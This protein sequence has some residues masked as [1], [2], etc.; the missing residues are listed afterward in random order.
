[1]AVPQPKEMPQNSQAWFIDKL[2]SSMKKFGAE[3]WNGKDLIIFGLEAYYQLM[4][5]PTKNDR[6]M[7]DDVLCLLSDRL[8]LAVNANLDPTGFRKGSGHSSSKGMGTIHY[9]VHK[10]AY[11]IGWHKQVY[12]AVR[13]VGE[14]TVRREASSSQKADIVIDGISYYF[15]KGSH[16]AMNM[17]PARLTSTSSLGCQTLPVGH[18]WDLFI[19]AIVSESKRLN[20]KRFTYVKARVRG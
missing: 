2:Q 12:P 20:Q 5:D 18:Q 1:M 16:Q 15:E 3:P 13:Q 14:I 11:A 9:G 6:A 7:F 10:D 4:G 19:R 8:F 17:H